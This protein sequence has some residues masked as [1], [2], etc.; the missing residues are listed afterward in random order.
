M[1]QPKVI[2]HLYKYLKIFLHYFNFRL[3]Y[4]K[5]AIVWFENLSLDDIFFIHLQG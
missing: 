5:M 4:N 2:Q 1:V 3:F